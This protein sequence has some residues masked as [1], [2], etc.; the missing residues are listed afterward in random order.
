M[1][2][3]ILTNVA[4]PTKGD[5]RAPTSATL[6]HARTY[7]NRNGAYNHVVTLDQ[8]LHTIAHKE[9]T[10]PSTANTMPENAMCPRQLALAAL[11]DWFRFGCADPRLRRRSTRTKDPYFA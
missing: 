1:K 6:Q 9:K 10:L 4:V 3:K 2:A 5:L 11:A 7:T 8:L